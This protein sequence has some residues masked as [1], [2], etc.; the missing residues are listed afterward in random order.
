V[1]LVLTAQ[2]VAPHSKLLCGSEADRLQ[3]C[4]SVAVYLAAN[5]S[6][7]QGDG[8]ELF[9]GDVWDETTSQ[10]LHQPT[11]GRFFILLPPQ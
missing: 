7:T 4:G 11:I 1:S 10:L 8:S 6:A 2:F 5:A 3:G 9:L